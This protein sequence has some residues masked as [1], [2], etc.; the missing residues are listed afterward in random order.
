MCVPPPNLANTMHPLVYQLRSKQVKSDCVTYIH[1]LGGVHTHI[2]CGRGVRTGAQPRMHTTRQH[3]RATMGN[4]QEQLGGHK[5]APRKN[6]IKP[7]PS[8]GHRGSHRGG[9]IPFL[10]SP[11]NRKVATKV[12]TSPCPGAL[13]RGRWQPRWPLSPAPQPLSRSDVRPAGWRA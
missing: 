5:V 4:C 2:G 11:G 7:N 12:A 13:G 3:E 8:G 1:M 9:H 10:W 6:N